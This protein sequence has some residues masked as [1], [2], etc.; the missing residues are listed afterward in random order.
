MTRGIAVKK[1][2]E[3][4]AVEVGNVTGRVRST[5]AEM[6][7]DIPNG[8]RNS[9][10][11]QKYLG[12]DNSLSWQV[13]R[14]LSSKDALGASR[15][16]PPHASMKRVFKSARGLGMP[17]ARVEAAE[18][19]IEEFEEMVRNYAGDRAS[20]GSMLAGLLGN[21]SGGAMRHADLQNR[22]AI[23]KG[24]S[25]YWGMQVETRVISSVIG[26]SRDY[27]GKFD[28]GQVRNLL[29]LVR[30]RPEANMPV[31]RHN[32]HK[33]DMAKVEVE[34]R[35]LDP[36]TFERCGAPVMGRFSSAPLP[37]FH[38]EVEEAGIVRT[39]M[40]SDEVGQKSRMDLTFGTMMCGAP[41]SRNLEGTRGAVSNHP[42]IW[43]PAKQLIV[44][45]LMHRAAFPREKLH[46][47]IKV[48]GHAVL[49]DRGD[50]RDSRGVLPF[51]ERLEYVGTG[52]SGAHTLDVPRQLEML[53]C[54][55]D[56]GGWDLEDF[57]VYRLK[58][59]Y[60][61]LDT[62]IGAIIEIED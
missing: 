20:F 44:N 42:R 50:L 57:D 9:R 3:Q 16:V 22:K 32:I 28:Y 14:L 59:D 6:L 54:V 1:L 11:V 15:F 45:M 39:E 26:P 41:I 55:V 36:E 25:Y 18:L 49:P 56:A 51:P 5:L 48:Q 29:G 38:C 46:P 21:G 2:D 35:P 7:G 33:F 43:I 30:F 24:H 17:V 34:R 12:V 31:D 53:R 8:V 13:F 61:L 62:T 27:P 52:D 19:A 40:L 23:F 37:E 4:F 60:P 58:I 47:F 10:D